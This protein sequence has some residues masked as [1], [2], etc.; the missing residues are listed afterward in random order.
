[1]DNAENNS[2]VNSNQGKS[3]T[4]SVSSGAA[5]TNNKREDLNTVDISEIT[6]DNDDEAGV[7]EDEEAERL[8][9]FDEPEQVCQASRKPMWLN[10]QISS[11]STGSQKN[12]LGEV[13]R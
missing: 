1:M 13:L 6:G 2:N 7:D 10:R 11:G 4:P 5:D 8:D 9:K 12:S 3:S